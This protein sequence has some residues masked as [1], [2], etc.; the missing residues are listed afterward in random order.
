MADRQLPQQHLIDQRE[1]RGV[2]ADPEGQRQDGH[3]REQRAAAKA[4]DGKA[5]IGQYGSHP[6]LGRMNAVRLLLAV[7]SACCLSHGAGHARGGRVPVEAACWRSVRR[8]GRFCR[9]STAATTRP[10]RAR[11]ASRML[12]F[13]PSCP[14]DGGWAP[15]DGLYEHCRCRAPPASRRPACASRGRRAAR[16]Q[17]RDRDRRTRVVRSQRP[18]DAARIPRREHVIGDVARD[19]AAGADD[20]PRSDRHAGQMI[21]RPADPD[22]GPD[23]HRLA[24]L[25]RSPQLGLERMRRGVDLHGGTEQREV[26]DADGADVEDDAVEVEEDALA[27][28]DVRP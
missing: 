8:R 4:A 26:A 10:S 28:K 19:D 12:D 13:W 1:D 27:E 6:V 18:N 17:W 3:D 23:R 22:V 9:A 5:E 24:E 20:G 2:G 7:R 21:G 15:L 25:P 11:A 16:T 14:S